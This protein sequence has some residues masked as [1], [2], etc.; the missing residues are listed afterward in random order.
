MGPRAI[1]GRLRNRLDH[2]FTSK[3]YRQPADPGNKRKKDR[4]TTL[5]LPAAK[6]VL[7]GIFRAATHGFG[8]LEPIWPDNYLTIQMPPPSPRSGR[9][10]SHSPLPDSRSAQVGDPVPSPT[11]RE[12]PWT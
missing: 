11:N 2:P 7:S 12:F 6:T 4:S 5:S 1:A 10:A 9:Q 8:L 3:Q